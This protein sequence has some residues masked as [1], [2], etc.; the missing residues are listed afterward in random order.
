MKCKLSIFLPHC[1]IQAGVCLL[2]SV[3]CK[4]NGN[5]QMQNFQLPPDTASQKQLSN[6]NDSILKWKQNREFAYMHYLDSVLRKEKNIKAD[7]VS[8]DESGK[9]TRNQRS[10]NNSSGLNRILNSLP[11]R[12]FF[13]ILALLFIGFISYKV[14]FKNG[15]LSRN[16]NKLIAGNEEDPLHDLEEFSKYDALISDA[17]N[18][19]E[20]NLATRYLF[21][22]TL[23]S[24]A[25]KGFIDFTTEKTNKEYLKE[26]QQNKSFNQFEKLTRN[27]EYIW[28]GKF[29]IGQN[30]YQHL[31]EEFILFNEKV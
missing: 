21:L 12:I 13:W 17:E 18:K 5:A 28:Y 11:L 30:I 27:Y 16:K 2:L 9:I 3:F 19:N 14:F 10:G 31:K 4:Y 20:F 26:M 8:I 22:K 24:L 1:A 25:D 29:L 7:T 6:N 23:K 15:I